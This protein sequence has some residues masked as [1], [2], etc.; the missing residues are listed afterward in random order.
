MTD[1][2][3]NLSNTKTVSFNNFFFSINKCVFYGL[4]QMLINEKKNAA[5]LY[6]LHMSNGGGMGVGEGVVVVVVE[7][8]FV[9]ISN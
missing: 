4:L 3:I 1:L 9:L 2:C 7:G 6:K 8:K 5:V